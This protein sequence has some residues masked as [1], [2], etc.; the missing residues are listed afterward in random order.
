MAAYF[1][2]IA[3]SKEPADRIIMTNGGYR[4]EQNLYRTRGIRIDLR[5]D[6]AVGGKATQPLRDAGL[7]GAGDQH[8]VC[9]FAV[10]SRSD[11][12]ADKFCP[13]FGGGATRRLT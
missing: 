9:G 5:A 6:C 11:D 12:L 7:C 1:S 2:K 4:N 13:Q 3:E 8:A 10:W